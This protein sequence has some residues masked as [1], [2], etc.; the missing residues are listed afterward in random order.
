MSRIRPS[1]AAIRGVIVGVALAWA[2]ACASS[3]A[4]SKVPTAPVVPPPSLDTR[5]A[6]LLRLE[7]QRV[8]RDAAA[9]EEAQVPQVDSPAAGFR[10]AMAPDLAQLLVDPDEAV[11]ARAALAIGRVGSA[12]G[13]TLL[14]GA[15]SDPAERVRGWAAF[16]LGV[17]G[18]RDAV[19][20]LLA[21]L[22]DP[23]ISVR[24]RVIEALGLIGDTSAA[25]PV[26][27]AAA[28]CPALIAAIEPD[29]EQYPKE[30]EIELCRLALYALVRLQN[31]EALARITLDA[32]GQPVS[33][34]WPVAYALQ[35]SAD[36]RAITA[37]RTLASVSGVYTAG[38][39]LRG[40]AAHDDREALPRA[41][42][43]AADR[44]V[45]VKLR[46][47]AVRL[48]GRVGGEPESKVLLGLLSEEP[49][50]SPLAVEVVTAL[51]T[52]RPAGVFDVLLDG[53]TD[54]S[55][56]MRAASL[57]AAAEVDPE[58]FLIV[59]SGLGRDRDWSVRAALATVMG[60][61]P[62]DRVTPALVDFSTDEDPRVHSAALRALAAVKVPDLH[63][64][65]R[66]ALAAEDFATRAT[67]AELVAE[68][69]PA[70][71]AALLADAYVRGE[72][73]S[74][75]AARLATVEA[76]A[77]FGAAGHETLRRALADREWPVRIKAAALLREAGVSDAE[78]ERPAPLRQPW[79]FF[80]SDAL[81]HPAY[82][83]RAF[84]E[85]RRGV[86]EIQ[87]EL[88][89]APLT[90][91]TFVE[92]VRSGLFDGLRVHRLVPAFVIQTGDP[93]GDGTGGPGYT[94]RD[95]LTPTP[96][97][98]GTVGMA[99][100]GAETAG[101]QWFIVTSPQ[102]HLD[103]KYTTF[104]RVVSGW[105]VLDQIAANDVIERVRIWD[106]VEL[107]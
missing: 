78:P 31:F 56:A 83:P 88:V 101:S 92:Q 73:D 49:S 19:A 99:L 12:E 44:S 25:I 27:E 29:D 51:G 70:D 42:A 74:T 43:L 52:L 61:L 50:S 10:Y 87:L 34:W 102:P 20:P 84:I 57:A 13:T 94:Q 58:G 5:I 76:I 41:R 35:R 54:P 32:E 64:R 97:L 9:T 17:M 95:E 68:V 103:A 69:K 26:A 93:R 75:Y 37:L 36:R 89:D 107:R 91:A 14:I 46:V 82:S 80:E 21:A 71:G 67:A 105:D 18:A 7:Q 11:R 96:Y 1:A 30:P 28:G 72:T 53:V 55:P 59:L 48:M 15:L 100:G 47:A 23:D 45:D 24:G 60:T 65:L 63:E 85:T 16:G 90:V 39:A 98:R 33:R 62:A 66:V 2:S 81:L 86:I 106:G 79:S 3:G 38:F 77:T 8:L 22:A 6:W 40:L 104:G 4:G